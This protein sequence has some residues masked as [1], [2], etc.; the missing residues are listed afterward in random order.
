MR[1]TWVISSLQKGL[2]R[3]V[4]TI[5]TTTTTTIARNNGNTNDSFLGEISQRTSIE[6]TSTQG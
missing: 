2:G 5:T 6:M 4:E 3:F 1:Q